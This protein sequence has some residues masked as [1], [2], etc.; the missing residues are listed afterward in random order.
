M[1]GDRAT[2]YLEVLRRQEALAAHL[3][4]LLVDDEWM[5]TAYLKVLGVRQSGVTVVVDQLTGK[6][7][8]V[9]VRVV[10]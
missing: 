10:S 4:R 8:E 3:Q 7:F 9:W 2:A 1:K 6:R 5:G